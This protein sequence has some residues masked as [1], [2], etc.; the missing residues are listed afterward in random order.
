MK[1][2]QMSRNMVHQSARLLA[3]LFVFGFAAGCW[4]QSS[5]NAAAD[6]EA[7]YTAQTNPNGVWSYGYSSGFTDRITLYDQTAQNGVNGPNAQNWLSS[8]VDIGNSPAAEY[9]NGSA[10]NDGNVDFLANEFLLVS[11]I[12]GQYSDLVFTAPAAGVYLVEASFRGAQYGVGTV[13][14]IVANGKVLFSSSVT[15]VGQTVP[16]HTKVKL[17]AGGRLVFSVGPGG[18]LQNTGLAATISSSAF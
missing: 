11:G 7:G 4:A 1:R 10:Y 9:N 17:K 13:V 12:G 14:G 3:I 6:F 8:S 16:F 2:M 18:G 15:S 5:Y